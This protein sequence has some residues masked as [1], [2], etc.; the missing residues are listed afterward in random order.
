[1]FWGV[2]VPSS[3]LKL[4]I[5]NLQDHIQKVMESFFEKI[6]SENIIVGNNIWQKS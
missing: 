6:E 4:Y 2:L 1:M 5:S 3:S